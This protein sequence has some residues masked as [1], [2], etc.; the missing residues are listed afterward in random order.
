VADFA[1]AFTAGVTLEPWD[2]PSSVSPDRPSRINPRP[3]H[4][5]KRHVGTTGVEVEVTAT[6]AGVAGPLDATLGG[7]LFSLSFHEGPTLPFP[8]VSSPAGQSSILRFTPSAVGH[9]TVQLSRPNHGG[10]ILHVDVDS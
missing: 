8:A 9:Y 10:V 6:V 3:E 2:D 4:I 5:H 7:E 1:A